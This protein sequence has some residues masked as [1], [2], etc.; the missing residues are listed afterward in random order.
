[1]HEGEVAKH[2]AENLPFYLRWTQEIVAAS[3]II[4]LGV[5]KAL[6]A[7]ELQ[8]REMYATTESITESEDRLKEHIT[9]ALRPMVERLEHTEKGIATLHNRLDRHLETKD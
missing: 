4:I 5:L 6:G 1:M 3:G 9:L 7:R 8:K 2:A